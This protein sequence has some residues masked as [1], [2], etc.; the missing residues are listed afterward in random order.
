MIQ[1]AF[2]GCSIDGTA[3]CMANLIAISGAAVIIKIM[4][5]YWL[6]QRENE[7]SPLKISRNKLRLLK[8]Q[9]HP[10]ILFASLQRIHHG[11]RRRDPGGAGNDLEIIRPAELLVV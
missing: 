7:C 5:D 9:M 8:M 2:A 11:N 1:A 4:K 3:R 6:Q 10:R